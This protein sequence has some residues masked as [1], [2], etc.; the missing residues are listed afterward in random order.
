M[1]EWKVLETGGKVIIE[2]ND[3]TH[4]VWLELSGDFK[5]YTQKANYAIGIIKLLNKT[6]ITELEAE[7]KVKNNALL[8][9]ADDV[10]KQKVVGEG[11]RLHYSNKYR[12]IAKGEK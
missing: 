7:L 5:D 11:R 12:A 1:S 6:R 4:D 3:F 10:E 2:S 9:A 8:E